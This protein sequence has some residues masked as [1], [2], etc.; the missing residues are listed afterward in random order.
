MLR[1]LNYLESLISKSLEKTLVALTKDEFTKR[2]KPCIAAPSLCGNMYTASLYCS[3]I[4]LMSNIDC[5]FRRKI[6]RIV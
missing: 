2:L 6:Y 1:R 3:L 5:K 4:S